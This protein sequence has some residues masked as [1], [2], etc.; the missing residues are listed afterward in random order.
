M[1][2]AVSSFCIRFEAISSLCDAQSEAQA[3]EL[4]PDEIIALSGC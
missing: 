4:R 2:L 3:A 1:G